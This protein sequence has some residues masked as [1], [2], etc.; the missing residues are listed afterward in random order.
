[1]TTLDGYLARMTPTNVWPASHS[2]EEA[3]DA[4]TK[5]VDPESLVLRWSSNNSCPMPDMLAAWLTLGLITRE[6]ADAT[7]A[8]R[9]VD[10]QAFLAEYRKN[11]PVPDAEQLFE[12][13]AAFGEGTEVV[14]VITGK[15]TVL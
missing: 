8:A 6:Q 3:R 13:R 1:M 9:D 2:P 14:D 11:P 10:T 15:T 4:I 7:V 5:V 12:M